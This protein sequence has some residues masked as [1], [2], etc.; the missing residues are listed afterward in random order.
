M[1]EAARTS[2]T[3]VDNYISEDKSELYYSQPGLPG[4]EPRV[5]A[6]TY[7]PVWLCPQL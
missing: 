1:T 6:R 7:C 4:A 2:E 5:T 3:S